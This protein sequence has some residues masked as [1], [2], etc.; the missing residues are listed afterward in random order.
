MESIILLNC[1]E[2]THKIEEEEK[3]RFIRS[4]LEGMGIPL[5]NI[6]DDNGHLTIQNKIRLREILHNY[7]VKII[8]NLKDGLAIYVENEKVAEWF[9]CQYKLKEDIS[10]IDPARRLFLEMK[11]SSWSIFEESEEGSL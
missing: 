8:D 3:S 6:Y 4:I 10:E 7:Q 11:I 5:D 9:Q 1:N 2:N